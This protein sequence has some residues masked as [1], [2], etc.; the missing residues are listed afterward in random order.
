MANKRHPVEMQILARVVRGTLS[1]LFSL[2]LCQCATQ[3]QP[4]R[5]EP[6]FLTVPAGFH[7]N[8][9]IQDK[10]RLETE[11]NRSLIDN[12]RLADLYRWELR[13]LPPQS[14]KALEIKT[15]LAQVEPSITEI[16]SRIQDV[17][18]EIKENKELPLANKKGSENSEGFLKIYK[19]LAKLWNDDQITEAL[20]LFATSPVSSSWSSQEK[21]RYY[22]LRFRVAL[23][24]GD[25][26]G[27]V[28]T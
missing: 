19:A 3:H 12:K 11:P 27:V 18:K 2:L 17:Q 16:E 25:R 28:I 10:I 8:E 7:K 4:L 22:Y 15:K 9:Y 1:F 6:Y 14:P 21:T 24:A 26:K 20:K 23:D 5:F 13:V